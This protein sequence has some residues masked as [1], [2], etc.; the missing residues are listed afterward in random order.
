[1]STENEPP[2]EKGEIGIVIKAN[3]NHISIGEEVLVIDGLKT[4][5]VRSLF[6]GTLSDSLCYTIQTNKPFFWMGIENYTMLCVGKD[7]IKRKKLP[8]EEKVKDTDTDTP[9]T[10]SSWNDPFWKEI[11]LDWKKELVEVEPIKTKKWN[12]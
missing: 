4:R 7:Q 1:M 2:L 11:G 3:C 8:P 12:E 9:N 10:L 6:N 5:H